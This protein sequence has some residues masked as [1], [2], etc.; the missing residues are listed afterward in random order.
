MK[1]AN[2]AFFVAATILTQLGYFLHLGKCVPV[3]TQRLICLGHLVDTT[4]QIFSIPEDKKEKFIALR[5][6]MLSSKFVSLNQL[7]HFL[8][9]CIS[10][11]LMVPAAQLYTQ[12]VVHAISRSQK[13]GPP[14]PLDGDLREEIL[15]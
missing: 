3:P 12:V 9:K 11:T 6:G 15:H 10:L 14:I 7:Q 2:A 1:T 13:Q 5:K 4:R 8:G